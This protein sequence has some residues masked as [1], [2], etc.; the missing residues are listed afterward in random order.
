MTKDDDEMERMV[1]IEQKMGR[2]PSQ[3]E[4]IRRP[5]AG[6]IPPM[7]AAPV[8]HE[9]VSP[10]E[11]E[12]QSHEE[13]VPNTPPPEDDEDEIMEDGAPQDFANA[14]DDDEERLSYRQEAFGADDGSED[15]G[16]EA[17]ADP[18][19]TPQSPAS[20]KQRTARLTS[21]SS[22]VAEEPLKRII[23]A[24]TTNCAALEKSIAA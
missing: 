18:A 3:D 8:M 6:D 24:I 23:S 7:P 15:S 14:E 17:I 9:P 11:P 4:R 22:T 1:A 5:D 19:S 20:K 16:R 13:P 2:L 10:A 21:Q 12:D